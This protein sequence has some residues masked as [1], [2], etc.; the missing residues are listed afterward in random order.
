M[1]LQAKRKPPVIY[2]LALCVMLFTIYFSLGMS[3]GFLQG[4]RSV[5]WRK[6]FAV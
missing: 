3:P 4:G 1:L 2:P 5:V 6:L